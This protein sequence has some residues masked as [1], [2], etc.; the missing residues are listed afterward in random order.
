MYVVL[1]KLI[2]T[3]IEKDLDVLK[4]KE[5]GIWQVH[6]AQKTA[7]FSYLLSSLLLYSFPLMYLLI[8]F[9]S[10][11]LPP[12]LGHPSHNPSPHLFLPFSSERV[13]VPP[14]PW[15]KGQG[16]WPTVKISDPELFLSKRTRGSKMEKRLKERWSNDQ[17]N[18]GSISW[19]GTKSWH[20][21]WCYDVLTDG[22]L[23][24]LSSKWPYQQLTEKE[25]D[26]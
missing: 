15:V 16:Y 11:S 14:G 22:S 9:T 12:L 5:H 6:Y 4:W 25:A 8:H 21:F 3:V 24:W 1:R 10:Q 26:T 7:L 13:E 2:Y 19:E 23:A 18:L 20:Y 17:P